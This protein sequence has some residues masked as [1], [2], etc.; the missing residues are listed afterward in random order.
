[1]ERVFRSLK[2][3]WIAPAS[4][5]TAQ[6]AQHDISH[7]LMHRYNWIRPHQSNDGLALARADEKF[8]VASGIS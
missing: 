5:R 4:Y 6:E 7:F 1:M 3:E 8:N 2:T